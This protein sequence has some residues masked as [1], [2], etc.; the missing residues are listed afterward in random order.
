M[1][2]EQ[3]YNY[4]QQIYLRIDLCN[5]KKQ[6]IINNFKDVNINCLLTPHYDNFSQDEIIDWTNEQ[7]TD[8]ENRYENI[9]NELKNIAHNKNIELFEDR[10]INFFIKYYDITF[11]DKEPNKSNESFVIEI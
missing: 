10:E 1:N 8:L 7:I 6:C 5:F 3:K 11:T 2:F 4:I 9:Y